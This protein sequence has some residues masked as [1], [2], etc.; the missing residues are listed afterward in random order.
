MDE[1]TERPTDA[2]PVNRPAVFGLL[3]RGGPEAPPDLDASE[4]APPDLKA[5]DPTPPRRPFADEPTQQ[6]PVIPAPSPAQP[7]AAPAHPTAAPA[8]PAA[9]PAR[10]AASPE[11]PSRSEPPSRSDSPRVEARAVIVYEPE[12]RRSW[13]LLVLTAVLVSLTVGVVLGQTV[14]DVPRT[15]S[16]AAQTQPAGAGYSTP[17]TAT[18]S[19][20]SQAVPGQ[21]LP[22]TGQRVSAP[23]GKIRAQQF[24]VSGGATQVTVR[25]V[26]LGDRLFDIAALD[27]SAVPR[28]V[29]LADGPRL[30]FIR[31]G[32]PGRIGAVIQL[33]SRVQWKLHLVGGAAEQDIDMR[34]GGLAGIDLIGGAS[35]AVLQ[36]PVP[37]GTVAVTVSGGASEL[38]VQTGPGVPVRV[39]LGKGADNTV[40]DGRARTK[41][42]PGTTLTSTGWTT[43]TNR[44]DITAPA[45]VNVLRVNHA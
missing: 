21:P 8:H 2:R 15:A 43:T 23:L 28:V 18:P 37:K 19:P 29:T 36:L 38:D 33:N 7:T 10:P 44:Y 3:S 26:D 40:I 12:P 20:S 24:E 42:R 41:V 22:V 14:A 31:T 45:K 13:G 6:F 4:P 39:R 1:N 17:P 27:D 9:A 16:A 11:G 30:D 34:A 35:R 32:A 25:S 5:A